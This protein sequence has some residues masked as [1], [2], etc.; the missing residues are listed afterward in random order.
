VA[1]SERINRI[2]A[3]SGASV[4]THRRDESTSARFVDM[5]HLM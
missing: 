4:S 2:A 3:P 5:H 1:I